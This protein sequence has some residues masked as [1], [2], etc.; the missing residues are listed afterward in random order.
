MKESEVKI[1]EPIG[2]YDDIKWIISFVIGWG[3]C[4]INTGGDGMECARQRYICR[5]FH[6]TSQ[7]LCREVYDRV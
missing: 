1:D 5:V 2:S 6:F 4:Y 7:R 3:V